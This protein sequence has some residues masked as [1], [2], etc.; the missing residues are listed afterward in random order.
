MGAAVRDDGAGDRVGEAGGVVPPGC[1]YQTTE[2]RYREVRQRDEI[3][4]ALRELGFTIVHDDVLINAYWYG[5]E[6]AGGSERE[7][8]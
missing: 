8:S 1:L 5:A 6:Y 2:M 3:E 7:S 4:E